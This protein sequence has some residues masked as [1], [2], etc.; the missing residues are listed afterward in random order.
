MAIFPKGI[1]LKNKIL[2]SKLKD[3]FR[4]FSLHKAKG[5]QDAETV[6]NDSIKI[7]EIEKTLKSREEGES[8]ESHENDAN[9]GADGIES[10]DT[11]TELLEMSEI[12]AE[13]LEA[14]EDEE[15]GKLE[16][17]IEENFEEIAENTKPKYDSNPAYVEDISK[18]YYIEA[19]DAEE[20]KRFED[21]IGPND[22][23]KEKKYLEADEMVMNK[24]GYQ[25]DLDPRGA[26]NIKLIEELKKKHAEADRKKSEEMHKKM[27]KDTYKSS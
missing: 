27:Y 17:N 3:L 2:E 16:E 13:A 12:E 4:Y 1:R 5:T 15:L 9:A 22:H 20:Y 7:E 25:E 26:C 6:K 8:L 11:E 10:F 18:D 24:R 23:Q 21:I 14:E 19:E